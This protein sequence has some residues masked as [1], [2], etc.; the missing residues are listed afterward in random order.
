MAKKAKERSSLVFQMMDYE[1]TVNGVTH[2]IPP[3]NYTKI[4]REDGTVEESGTPPAGPIGEA[5]KGMLQP[6]AKKPRRKQR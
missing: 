1:V 2:K 5:I 4:V 3:I 6:P